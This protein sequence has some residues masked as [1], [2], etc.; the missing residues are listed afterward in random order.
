MANIDFVSTVEF[1]DS[2]EECKPKPAKYFIPEWFK[3]IPSGIN[4]TVKG[5][6]SFPDFF[7]Q[8]YI[9]PMWADFKLRYEKETKSWEWLGNS[10]KF[11]WSIHKNDQFIDYVTPSFNGSEAEFVFKADCPW[12]I[13]TPPGWS[14]L[15]LPLFYHFNKEWSVMP[16][17]IDTDIHHYVNQQVL[18]HGEEKE[19][20]I[21]RGDPF[22]LY[23]PFK[24]EK[25]K[26]NVRYQNKKDKKRIGENLIKINTKFPGSGM[27][28]KSQRERDADV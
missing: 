16:G 13:I 26:L 5:C 21:N 25:N 19:I 20:T 23:I 17:V 1:L 6:P 24:R 10:E 8:G 2:I 18:Y 9:I 12:Q 7:S 28:R 15:Q 3:E 14:V 11:T 22:A 4:G 27:Y